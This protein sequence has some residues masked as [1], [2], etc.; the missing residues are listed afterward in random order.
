LRA[1]VDDAL[2]K[3]GTGALPGSVE[4]EQIDFRE[5]AGRRG[6]G[7]ILNV[8]DR[9]NQEAARHLASE[10]ACMANIPGGGAIVVGVE[11]RS[12]MLLGAAVDAD[13]LR[14]RVYEYAGV[15][16]AVTER[17]VRGIR[18]LVLCVA[19]AGGPAEDVSGRIRWRTGGR[20]TPVDRAQW[21]LNR[22]R[23][24]GCDLMAAAT[25]RHEADVA[26]GA[27]VV[28]RRYLASWARERGTGTE[29]ADL[30]GQSPR[31]LLTGL[32]V[33]YPDGQLS[34]AGAL[35]FCAPGRTRI[36]L[37]VLDVEGGELLAAPRDLSGLSLLEQIA[38]VD[39]RLGTLN[40]SLRVAA[41]PGFARPS[42]RRLPA[43][44]VREAVLNGVVHRDWMQHDPLEVT[45]V[46]EDSALQVVSPGGF[47]GGVTAE[48]VLTQRHARLLT[49]EDLCR[50]LHL[51]DKQGLGVDRMYRDMV[52]LGH[53]P[54]MI[55]EEPG[56]RV[57]TRL[58]GGPPVAP[59][60]NLM[61]TVRPEPR[62]RDVR[63]ALIIYTLLHQPYTTANRLTG[64]LQR[65]IPEVEE[66][67]E[68]AASCL[69][70]SEPLIFRYKD[71][72]TLTWE[73]VSAAR[74]RTEYQD[75]HRPGVLTYIKPDI[76][77]AATIASDWLADHDRYTSGDHVNLTGL[78]YAGARG[79]LE[80][81]EQAGLLVRGP[82]SG[83]SAHF[84][85]GLTLS[86]PPVPRLATLPSSRSSS[87]EAVRTSP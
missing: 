67:L 80:R 75:L 57:R 18:L 73:A 2:A 46:Q 21:W 24:A 43:G 10:V 12:G 7:G 20:C 71:V 78:T 8:G 87:L 83:R 77:V 15:A 61:S 28:A 41:G 40:T 84:M 22:Q 66:A 17:V 45:W 48:N 35:M 38:L 79:Q 68:T 11:D 37:S 86:D 23:H 5:E 51:A 64:I 6:P 9:H 49:L 72:W 55:V 16:P 50:A 65:E 1:L 60:V 76:N 81:L 74:R 3:L 31:E 56:P 36:A 26:P 85:A 82:G 62:Q 52:V 47:T 33:L 54:P 4:R 27:L 44:A 59:V 32:G 42:V 19:H 34:A 29:G 70:D 14:R 53:R 30:A 58:A 63:V 25:K 13:W 39:D 69:T